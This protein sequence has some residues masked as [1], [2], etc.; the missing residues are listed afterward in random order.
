[1][2]GGSRRPATTRPRCSSSSSS[3]GL[4]IETGVPGVYGHGGDF[5]D[6]RERLDRAGDSAAA[7]EQPEQLRFPPVLPRRQLESSGYLKSFPHLAGS[8]FAFD[9][10]ESE[11]AAQIERA[12]AHE[13]WSEFQEMTEL[14]LMPAA[15]YP[16]YPAIAARGPLP[17]R[18]RVVDAG[19]AW[20]FRHEPSRRPGPPADVPPARARPDRR[21]RGRPRRGATSGRSAGSSCCGRSASSRARRRQRPVLRAPRADA[22]RQPARAG[23]EARD[24]RPDRR[25]RADRCRLIQPPPASTSPPTYG[26]A[27]GR[28]RPAHTACLG[29]GQERIVLALLRTHG[30]DV[31]G[32]AL[33]DVARELWDE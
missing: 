27:L 10:A 31:R 11:A 19:G 6:V 23:A 3:D 28:R 15:C 9:G 14:A 30:L 12:A 5:E 2:P 26:I 4:L 7:P 33:T 20:V 22:R 17:R 25:P 24:A 1:M 21:A 13:D 29:F 8:M 32:L 16:V 18:R